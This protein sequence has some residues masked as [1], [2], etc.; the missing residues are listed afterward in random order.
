MGVDKNHHSSAAEMFRFGRGMVW[1]VDGLDGMRENL[2]HYL[3]LKAFKIYIYAP[4]QLAKF[5]REL[6]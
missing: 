1:M 4:H 3:C 5:K 2:E 6:L